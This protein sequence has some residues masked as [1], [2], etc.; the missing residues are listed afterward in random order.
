VKCDDVA[1]TVP[2]YLTDTL[3]ARARSAV[4]AHLS[5]CGSGLSETWA[6]LRVLE[7]ARPSPALRA[8]FYAMLEAYPRDSE[9]SPTPR[10][11]SWFA[12]PSRWG[13]ASWAL[14][15]A[16]AALVLVAGFALGRWSLVYPGGPRAGFPTVAGT[17]AAERTPLS[18]IRQPSAGER[19]LGV[20]QASRLQ[21]PDE[22]LVNALLDTVDED[23]NVNVRLSAVEA[24]YLFSQEPRI[25]ERLTQSLA[26]QTSPVVQIA[27]ID[28]LVASREKQ[29][30]EAL[31]R[32]VK[33]RQARPEVREHAES[34]LKRLL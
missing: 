7:E 14:Q 10:K 33:D 28:L 2:D 26:R 8:G 19:L 20:E 21:R 5:E 32:L 17:A 1:A 15:P 18:L 27:L 23:P 31:G 13:H 4:Q 30:A 6:R 34:G 22:A 3:D 25:R 29:A 12:M 24:L 16:A 11:R 9:D